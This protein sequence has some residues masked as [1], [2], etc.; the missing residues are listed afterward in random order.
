MLGR[1]HRRATLA[2]TFAAALSA[3]AIS[4]W[5][6]SAQEVPDIAG[7]Y[8]M[9]GE[10]TVEGSP[11]RFVITGKLVV[12][13]NGKNCTTI[14]EAA[15]RRAAGHSG[16]VSAALIGTGTATLEGRKFTGKSELQSLVSEVPE[17]DVAVPF[18]P[19]TAGPVLDATANGEVLADG[20][21]KLEIRSTLVGE[22]FTLPEGRRTI[23]VAKRV[24]R[25][26][27]ELKKK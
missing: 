8:E 11:D 23:V 2:W 13:Q 10:M 4:P 20:S 17:L 9:N 26:P 21:L 16:P 7:I 24:A 18:A 22:G 27:T 19:R 15:I 5:H 14:T 25:S 3:L 6:A 12:R 1:P